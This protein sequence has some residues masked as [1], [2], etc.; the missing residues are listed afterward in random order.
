MHFMQ[1]KSD[2]TG[3]GIVLILFSTLL[4]GSY[5]VWSKL[6]GGVRTFFQGWTRGL[7]ISSV[8]LISSSR[9]PRQPVPW[10]LSNECQLLATCHKLL[11]LTLTILKTAVR[12]VGAAALKHHARA[13]LG[14]ALGTVC[15]HT[16]SLSRFFHPF[17]ARFLLSFFSI[18]I[19]VGSREDLMDFS[20]SGIKHLA[21][22]ANPG[23]I[24]VKLVEV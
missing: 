18:I 11:V 23:G 20:R 13:A 21:F 8:L 22:V 5:D 2:K 17:S 3:F 16:A 1:V 12:T 15:N 14:A 10:L 24:P 9:K 19:A 6:M 7:I 4:F